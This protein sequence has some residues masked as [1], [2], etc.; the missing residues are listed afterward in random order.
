MLQNILRVTIGLFGVV[1]IVLAA[2]FL[3]DPAQAAAKLGVG[4]LGPLGVAT[5]RGDFLGFF[6]AG[7]VLAIVAAVRNDARHLAAPLLLIAM[8][9]A[10]RL[11]TVVTS[12]Y[13]AAI[14]PPMLAEAVIVLLLV[15]GRRHLART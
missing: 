4:P 13:D 2:G 3:L 15:F 6:G 10:G 1:F 9:L 12:G 11:I 14:G 8:A 5:L 7:G